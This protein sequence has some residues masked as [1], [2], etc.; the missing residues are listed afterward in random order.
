MGESFE[1][2]LTASAGLIEAGAAVLIVIGAIEAFVR[3]IR[4]GFAES[5]L[6]LRARHRIWSN[7]G[8]WLMLG[9]EFELAADVIRSTLA[10]TW[11]DIG[12]LAAIAVIRTFLNFFLQQDLIREGHI[13]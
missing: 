5:N 1:F 7:F 12:Q 4:N 10:P 9:L 3:V 11:I 2:V 6:A 13:G 8:T